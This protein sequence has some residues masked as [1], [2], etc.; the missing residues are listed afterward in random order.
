MVSEGGISEGAVDAAAALPQPGNLFTTTSASPSSPSSPT[1]FT[2]TFVG[3]S[4]TSVA[5]T[6]NSF[7]IP[8]KE[9]EATREVIEVDREENA[10]KI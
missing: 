7:K 9:S 1:S 5:S 3:P 4:D 2:S 6:S 8:A 10:N